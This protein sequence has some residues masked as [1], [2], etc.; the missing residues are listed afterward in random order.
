MGDT[1]PSLGDHRYGHL[2]RLALLRWS[3]NHLA[4][5]EGLEPL[6]ASGCGAVV[7][8]Q[9]R[10]V[11]YVDRGMDLLLH[12]HSHPRQHHLGADERG[13]SVLAS[14]SCDARSFAQ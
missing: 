13:A 6:R 12:D 9:Y 3:A 4:T 11:G 7:Q 2:C 10:D 1:R 14:H 8:L 5:Q